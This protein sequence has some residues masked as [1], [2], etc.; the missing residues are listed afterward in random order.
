ML[1]RY[2]SVGYVQSGTP[3]HDVPLHIVI[4]VCDGFKG[5]RGEI[6][7]SLPLAETNNLGFKI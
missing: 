3:H 7:H 4:T 1:N 5:E 2:I 6:C